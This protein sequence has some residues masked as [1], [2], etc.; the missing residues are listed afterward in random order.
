MPA[1]KP[2]ESIEGLE[3]QGHSRDPLRFLSN[4]C[5]SCYTPSRN[6]ERITETRR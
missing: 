2:G 5:K 6:C 3:I 1:H 4:Q